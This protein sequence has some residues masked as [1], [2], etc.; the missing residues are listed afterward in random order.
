MYTIEVE[1]ENNGKKIIDTAEFS[2]Y[3]MADEYID[4]LSSDKKF[5][6]KYGKDEIPRHL[7]SQKYS[8]GSNVVS[9]SKLGRS[10]THISLSKEYPNPDAELVYVK[11]DLRN[12]SDNYVMIYN[13]NIPH[14][15]PDS[16]YYLIDEHIHGYTLI[17]ATGDDGY[18]LIGYATPIFSTNGP[19]THKIL[20]GIPYYIFDDTL[21]LSYEMNED[22]HY[23]VADTVA[24][25]IDYI[26]TMDHFPCMGASLYIAR[27]YDDRIC[28][29]RLNNARIITKNS[30][31]TAYI[32]GEICIYD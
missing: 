25:L 30:T 9:V 2:S 19:I 13:A 17:A 4:M 12:D 20:T 26:F 27:K 5:K 6:F 29:S 16:S 7:K 10:L 3:K 18:A 8:Y 23:I 15:S 14:D 11:E 1:K 21:V 31:S 22:Q 24:S 28:V 32:D